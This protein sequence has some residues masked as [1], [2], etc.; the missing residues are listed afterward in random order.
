M[1]PIWFFPF[2]L[3]LL[4][5]LCFCFGPPLNQSLAAQDA[6][7]KEEDFSKRRALLKQSQRIVFLGDSITYAGQYVGF[8][9]AWLLTQELENPPIVVNVGLPSETVSGLSEDGHADGKFPRPDVAERLERVLAVTKPDLVIA[10]YGINCG[11]YQPLDEQR[12][13]RYQQGMKHLKQKVEAVGAALIVMTPPTYDDRRGKLPFSY[14]AVLNR[15]AQWLLDQREEGWLVVDVHR[16][17]SDA[18]AQRQKA[19]PDFTFQPDAVH[20]NSEGHWAMAQE[21]ILWFGDTAS[22]QA[23][24]P[25]QMLSSHRISDDVLEVVEQ[26]LNLRRDAY[27]SASGHK[28]PGIKAG[29]PVEDAE[30]QTQKLTAKIRELV[31]KKPEPARSEAEVQEMEKVADLALVPPTLNTSPLPGY[32]YDKLDYGMTIGI[33]R[34]LGGRL[35]ACWVAGGDSPKAFFVLATSDDDGETWSKPRLVVDSHDKSLPA[36][37][38]V[39]VGNLWTDPLGRLWLFFDQSMDMFDGRAGVWAAVCENPDAKEPTWSMPRRIWHGV[40]LNKPTVL[41]TGEWMLPISLD[42]R[43]GFRQFKGCFKELD[44]LRGANVF[45]ST[46]KGETWQRRGC[47]KFPNPDWHEHMIVERKDGSLWMLARTATGLMQSTSSDQGKTWDEPSHGAIKHPVARFHIRRLASGRLLLVKHGKTI[48]THEGRS[49]LTAWLSDDDGKTWQGGLML[50]ERKG[51][52]YPDGFQAPDGTIYI[53]YDR[54]RATDGEILMAK[55]T[56]EDILARKLVGPKSKL[57]MLI[58]RPL[59]EKAAK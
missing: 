45:V 21:V 50:D 22:A 44:P 18:L 7:E 41:S 40:M 56:E 20:P 37:R 23:G 35:W 49:L 48:D 39:L 34:T 25:K 54:N 33:E 8:F 55:F 32:D 5:A 59:A 43:P 42:Q 36:E 38:S 53:S 31:Q 9:E 12:F 10:C 4:T 57:R 29:V 17:M 24:S 58:S 13:Q 3:S 46:D 47:V 27:L 19:N 11:I 14:N 1:R 16:P 15:Y 2:L 30:K 26:R 28:R 52:S 51:I 6:I